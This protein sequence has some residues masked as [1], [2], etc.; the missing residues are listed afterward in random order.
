M[1]FKKSAVQFLAVICKHLSEKSPLTFLAARCLKFFS[2]N[3]MVDDVESC[4]V[5]ADNA[6]YQYCNFLSTILKENKELFIRFDNR[7]DRLDV[8]V[9]SLVGPLPKF[10]NLRNY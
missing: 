10:D 3:Y 5:I 7:N 8:F 1:N 4:L 2:P 9:W 6:K